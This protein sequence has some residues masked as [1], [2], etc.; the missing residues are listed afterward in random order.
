[1]PDLRLARDKI[2]LA[3][4][5]WARVPQ[6]QLVAPLRSALQ[7]IA[8]TLPKLKQSLDEAVPLIEMIVPIAGYPNPVRYLV[9]LQNSD[10]LRPGGG[11][12]GNVGTMTLDGGDMTELA[13]TD[14]Y[15][16][17]NP[18]SFNWKEV[19]PQQIADRMGVHGWYLRDANWSPD[20]PTSADRMLDFYTR[21][22][23]VGTGKPLPNPP[24]AVI[25]LEPGFFKALLHITGAVTVDGKTYTEDTFF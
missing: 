15:S 14:V 3:L 10:E 12:I 23:Q 19:P 4:E 8:D 1:M 20:F 9:V 24:T 25:A 11:F 7:P 18:A 6:D 16:V 5:L 22:I 13:F 21:E 2:D 17:D